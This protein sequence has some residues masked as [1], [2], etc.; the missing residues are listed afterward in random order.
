[1]HRI[2]TAALTLPFVMLAETA[3]AGRDKDRDY[4]ERDRHGE[5]A[6]VV[7]TRPIFENVTFSSPQ[8]ECR[9][10]TRYERRASS[11][12]GTI[13]GGIAGGVVGNR[14]GEGQGKDAM[15]VAG[16]LLGA[17]I[18]HEATRGGDAERVT[19]R[20]CRIT[21]E[22]HEEQRVVGYRVTYRYHG[23]E[24]TTRLPYQPGEWIKLRVDV[25]PA[26]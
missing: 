20:R 7:E 5:F 19:T 10:E 21:H 4:R 6:R 16:A 13:L 11:A 18:A 17:S 26:Y 23:R 3:D 1:M 25:S 24:Y 15:T 2:L 9:E 8:R 22:V 12:T 14:F